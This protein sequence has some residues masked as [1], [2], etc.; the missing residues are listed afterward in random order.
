MPYEEKSAWIMA[1]V[2]IITFAWYAVT[3]LERAGAQPLQDVPYV[4]TL[5][6]TIGVAIVLTIIAHIIAAAV[7]PKDAGKVDQ[8][9]REISRYGEYIGQS[10]VVIGGVAAGA[11]AMM[12]TDHF[13]IANVIYLSF[14][15]SAILGSAAK[16]VAYRRGFRQW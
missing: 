12:E 6:W 3:V 11:L 8:R 14:A 15:L 5:L 10:L 4:A 1:G 2:T 9:D 13:W 16:I 7:S